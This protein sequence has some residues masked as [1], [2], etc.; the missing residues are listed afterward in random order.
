MPVTIGELTTDV[1]A[2]A[3][4]GSAPSAPAPHDDQKDATSVRARL[5][6]IARQ[7]LR[8][9]AEGFDD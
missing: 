1:I 6:V 7:V 4:D 2:E 8:T 9:R 3:G 5:A